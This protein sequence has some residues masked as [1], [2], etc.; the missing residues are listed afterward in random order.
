MKKVLITGSGRCGTTFLMLIY[1]YLGQDTGWG[2]DVASNLFKNCNSGLENG[3]DSKHK[4]I[5]SPK[6]LR[7]LKEALEKDSIELLDIIIPIRD[8][9]DVAKSRERHGY[10]NGGWQSRSI[11]NKESQIKYI[12]ESYSIFLSV[13]AKYD[14]PFTLIDFEK[15]T[16]DSRYLF[17]KIKH[18]FE[19]NITYEKFEKSYKMASKS[20]KKL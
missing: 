4:I 13:A 19:N 8:I 12:Q 9:K 1:S 7:L 17:D 3:L 11:N 15:M 18:T 16:N 20:Q 10:N 5:K 2:Q 14:L 6:F